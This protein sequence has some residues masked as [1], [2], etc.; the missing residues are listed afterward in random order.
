M[1]GLLLTACVDYG[2]NDQPVVSDPVPALDVSPGELSFGPI[3]VGESQRSE[4]VL[5]SVGNAP[6]TVLD[7]RI[8]GSEAFALTTPW[9]PTELAVDGSWRVGLSFTP[10]SEEHQAEL[11]VESDAPGAP[12]QAVDL[13]GLGSLPTLE[14]D[15]DPLD[16]GR[17]HLGCERSVDLTLR[18]VGVADLTVTGVA[19][20]GAG[21]SVSAPDDLPWVL[22]AGD[23]RDLP[24]T[25]TPPS[26]DDHEGLIWVSSDE[27]LGQR[28][29][30]VEGQGNG[31][32]RLVEELRQGDGPWELADVMF[33][34]DRSCSMGD[35]TSNLV[36]NFS[37]FAETLG[38]AEIDWQVGIATADS[39]CINNGVITEDT[40]NLAAALQDAAFQSGGRYT[41]ALLTVAR[42]GLQAT[43]GCNAGLFRNESK[44][45]VVMV[46]DEP[47]QS[48]G[49]WDSLVADILAAAPLVT[50]NAVVGDVPD[51]C[52]SA[53]PGY[54]YSEAALATG[55]LVQSICDADWSSHLA[56]IAEVVLD[57][58][59]DTFVL[60][61]EPDPDSLEVTVAGEVLA[62]GW[63]F[64]VG[65]NAVVFDAG[66]WPDPNT[67][68]EVSYR[69]PG[70][71][72]E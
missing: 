29:G 58:Y 70:T 33:L 71:C 25:F 57:P 63:H 72:D 48:S 30:I 2:V 31:D 46:S 26:L 54:G 67:V 13:W 68:F 7:V 62:S 52:P 32:D 19:A 60:E 61:R 40:P 17:V 27:A 9:E 35:D 18:N 10:S 6:V 51:G 36:A 65:L 44:P 15:P 55:G 22:P 1:I 23:E 39:G 11:V 45:M 12:E 8:E 38:D 21:F 69:L 56:L 20:S 16:L 28:T 42:A 49:S 50:L 64:D 34:V 37:A 24:V 66:L 5:T 14:L 3:P 47:E 59:T 4:V 43:D 53:S 41:E